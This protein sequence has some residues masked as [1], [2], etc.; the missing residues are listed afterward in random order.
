[1]T[2]L[3]VFRGASDEG[4]YDPTFACVSHTPD[5]GK[6]VALEITD[7]GV[8]NRTF[9]RASDLDSLHKQMENNKY[10][11]VYMDMRDDEHLLPV[12]THSSSIPINTS[13]FRGAKSDMELKTLF[14]LSDL[15]ASQ[16]KTSEDETG[17][18]GTIPTKYQTSFQKR[19]TDV[20]TEYRG[21][22]RE[23]DTGLVVELS[24]V[25]PK[26]IEWEERLARV[27]RGLE[28]VKSLSYIGCKVSDLNTLMTHTLDPSK[29][30]MY[31]SVVHH[32]G[33]MPDES[34]DI[35][36][37]VLEQHEFRTLGLVIGDKSGN[38]AC[39]YRGT[40]TPHYVELPETLI[41]E[42]TS[43]EPTQAERLQ[44][45]IDTAPEHIREKFRGI[46]IHS[47]SDDRL[48]K[49]ET[50]LKRY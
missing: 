50:V 34:N 24:R 48:K 14:K 12:P 17:F 11:S 32:T 13:Q 23:R 46:D 29:D 43:K 31:G 27:Y 3:A 4:R 21:G 18:R 37:G 42:L 49:Y 41:N 9:Y 20:F 26:T 38:Q 22:V 10:T 35:P 25:V 33:Y 15:V 2:S 40:F 5:G 47:L 39:V 1:M 45:M 16:L 36:E 44:S 6:Y 7:S 30:E 19:E 28:V 8:Q